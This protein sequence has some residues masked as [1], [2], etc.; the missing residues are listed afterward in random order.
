M[1]MVAD[2]TAR[3][4]RRDWGQSPRFRLLPLHRCV[5]YSFALGAAVLVSANAS[6]ADWRFRSSVAAK[7]TY[8]DNVRL[9]PRGNEQSDWITE[10]TPS[11]G[12]SARGA[13]LQLSADYAFTYKAYANNEQSNG[14]SNALRSNALLDVWDRKLFLQGAASVAQQNI[15]TLGAL[16][17]STSNINANQSEVRQATLSPYW[18]SRLGSIANLRAQLTLSRAE[19]DGAAQAL[20]SDTQGAQITFSSGSAFSDLGWTV[21]YSS[22]QSE[23]TTGQFSKRESENY[24]AT[25]RYRI[26]P[27]LNALWTAGRDDNSFG[28]ARGATGGTFYTLGFDWAP[29]PR[30]KVNAQ[31]GERYFG[32]TAS[33]DASHR[34][35]LTTWQATYS[36][37]IVTTPGLYSSPQSVDTFIA[38]DRL[39]LTQFPDPIERQQI[40]EAYI[41]QNGLPNTLTTSVDFLTN[42][43]SLVKRLQ[44]V[45]GL[46]GVRG[47]LLMSVFHSDRESQT[48]DA[49]VLTTDPFALGNSVIQVGYSGVFSWR[50][51]EFTSGSAS[52]GQQKSKS[53]GSRTDKNNTLRLGLTHRL[54]PKLSGSVEY[55]FLDRDSSAVNADVRENAVVGTLKMSF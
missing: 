22:S 10:L 8:T 35:R 26:W 49:P 43:V 20:S 30:T 7:E 16:S 48:T 31:V 18:V 37:Q 32:K 5:R 29:S 9:A 33:L 52:L 24:T 38:V 13:R 53:V 46:R 51:S 25:L 47:S 11:V 45:F 4:L 27:T 40:V 42:Q 6:S 2:R 17:T 3:S 34:T 19:S 39:F 14:H 44:G 15:S 21:A 12:V 50:F 41:A 54:G 55:R 36:E 1:G 28:N 23:S